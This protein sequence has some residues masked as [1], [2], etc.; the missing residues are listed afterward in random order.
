MRNSF[1]FSAAEVLRDATLTVSYTFNNTLID[2]GPLGINGTSSNV[3]YSS[4][5]RRDYALNISTTS[6]FVQA[7]GLVYLGTDG[8]SYSISLWIQPMVVTSGTIIHLSP[9]SGSTIWSMPILGFLGTGQIRVQGCSSSGTVDLTGPIS[10]PGVWTHIAITY[11]QSTRFR[12]WVNG[13]LVAISPSSFVSSTIDAPVT[14]TLGSSPM[15]ASGSCATTSI[16]MSQYNGL[17]DEFQLY[18]RELTATEI[19]ILAS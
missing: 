12:L 15:S 3:Q 17:I 5:G 7:Y 13:T 1:F 9:S 18:S 10:I 8:Y 16:V 14:I 6:S 2:D 4:S 11:S 19:A